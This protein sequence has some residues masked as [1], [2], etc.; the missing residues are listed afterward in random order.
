[1]ADDGSALR[2]YRDRKGWSQVQLAA[3]LGVAQGRVSEVE[4]SARPM[5]LTMG[6]AFARKLKHYGF[7]RLA[8]D[9]A[10]CPLIPLVGVGSVER[11][12]T[13]FAAEFR[14]REHGEQDEAITDGIIF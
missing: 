5:S 2:Q 9:R 12:A 7:L 13:Q 14:M 10:L 6:V 1:M 11:V 3:R 4:R 8:I